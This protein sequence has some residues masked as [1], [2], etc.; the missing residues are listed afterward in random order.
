MFRPSEG[1]FDRLWQGSLGRAGLQQAPLTDQYGSDRRGWR[2]R[3]SLV[4]ARLREAGF[5][6]IRIIDE[7]G[8]FGGTWYW[9]RYPAHVPILEGTSYM[10]LLEELNHAPK[11]R[12]AYAS[13]MLEVRP[14]DRS[15]LRALR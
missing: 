1:K 6:D 3:R 7:A 13:E 8:D 4:G 11:H 10:P 15:A 2:L 14:E 9:N 12:Y 5:T